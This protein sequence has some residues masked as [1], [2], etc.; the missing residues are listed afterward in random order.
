M[1]ARRRRSMSLN[2]KPH[3]HAPARTFPRHE[4]CALELRYVLLCF[5]SSVFEHPSNQTA[6]VIGERT[7]DLFSHFSIVRRSATR[8]PGRTAAS[9][10][11]LPRT[12]S[13]ALS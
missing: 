10:G 5:V 13:L 2:L 3:G 1:N 8:C 4:F 6:L 9:S 12:M 7:V 11:A